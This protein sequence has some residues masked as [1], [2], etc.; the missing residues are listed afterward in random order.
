MGVVV[1]QLHLQQLRSVLLPL[2]LA[3][4]SVHPHHHQR[5][6]ALASCISV[7]ALAC[8]EA[9]VSLIA[10]DDQMNLFSQFFNFFQHLL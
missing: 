9:S 2:L 4:Q 3:F 10:L 8:Y 5:S 1:L 6:I 7:Q